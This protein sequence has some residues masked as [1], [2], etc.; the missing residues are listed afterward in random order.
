MQALLRGLDKA[1]CLDLL[2]LSFQLVVTPYS[3]RLQFR[4]TE[5]VKISGTRAR[6]EEG[7]LQFGQAQF[8]TFVVGMYGWETRC[9]M[10]LTAFHLLLVSKI[11]I[12]RL[13]I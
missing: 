7:Y 6:A 3:K 1:F 8:S 10:V 11:D 4:S 12:R 9:H 13:N 5:L 2:P